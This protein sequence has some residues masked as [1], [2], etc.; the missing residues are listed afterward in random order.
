VAVAEV[1]MTNPPLLVAQVS[2]VVLAVALDL[3]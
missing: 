3:L 1:D 2:Q